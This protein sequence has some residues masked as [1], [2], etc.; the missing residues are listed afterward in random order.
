LQKSTGSCRTA[1]R[2]CWSTVSLAYAATITR[3]H[4][5]LDDE[6]GAIR[7]IYG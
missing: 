2:F 5:E 1:I 6:R 3:R 7:T 4:Q